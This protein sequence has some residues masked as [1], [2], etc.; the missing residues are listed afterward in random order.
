MSAFNLLYK[1]APDPGRLFVCLGLSAIPPC[2]AVV[3]QWCHMYQTI[4]YPRC[5]GAFFLIIPFELYAYYLGRPNAR[6]RFSRSNICFPCGFAPLGFL[7]IVDV[8]GF[9]E[10]ATCLPARFSC[11]FFSN[12]N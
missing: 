4:P 12:S 9:R 7:G 3:P 2:G 5:R 10:C 6:W 8:R 1:V 11:K